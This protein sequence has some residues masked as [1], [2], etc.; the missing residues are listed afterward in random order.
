MIND[1][2]DMTYRS[3]RKGF[4]MK[5]YHFLFCIFM[6]SCQ[7]QA[8]AV[9]DKKT[10]TSDIDVNHPNQPQISYDSMSKDVT[11]LASDKLKGRQI[12]TQE[13]DLAANY[14][15]QRFKS[16]GLTS[17]N[18]TQQYLQTFTAYQITPADLSVNINNK[19]YSQ[20]NLTFTS[21]QEKINW[22]NLDNVQLSTIKPRDDFFKVIKKLNQQGGQHLV[23]V[24]P[25]HEPS[26]QR[27]KS[28]LN[29]PST[30]IDIKTLAN[31][32]VVLTRKQ[33]VKSIEVQATSYQEPK[34]LNN[35]VGLIPGS[36]K[37]D[38]I[39]V[40]SAHYDHLGEDKKT[41]KD[42]KIFN[43]ADDNASGTTAVIQLANF[44]AQQP[45][46]PKRTLMFVLFTAEEVGGIGSKY[47]SQ[48]VDANNITAM[49]N[50][51]MIGKPSKFGEGHV[52]VTGF[53]HSNMALQMNKTL[54]ASNNM[55]RIKA[56]PYPEQTL[57]YRSDNA[58]LARLGVPAH[59]FSSVQLDKDTHYHNVSD[60]IS[61]LNLSSMHQVI[62]TL[63]TASQNLVNGNDTPARISLDSV[64]P[65]NKLF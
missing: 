65:Q 21:N 29:K 39:V 55:L 16:M 43:G 22:Q 27:L 34:I 58:S 15:S 13:I 44:Y 36:T 28:Y 62:N 33:K 37:P 18:N 26:F 63:A 9:I 47:F 57:F 4:I 1:L 45:Q 23:L 53:E 5:C 20:R 14:I 10:S 54:Q 32:V 64:V 48:Q 12:Y 46:A 56:D 50:I 25:K 61:S 6:L 49:V 41:A 11:F 38:E 31:M 60:D 51:E 42:D 30:K 40:F 59:T 8:L 24:N 17:L 52:W 19:R 35:V 2:N 3:T 7:H